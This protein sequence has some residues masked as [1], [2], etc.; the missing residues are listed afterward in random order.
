MHNFFLFTHQQ[1][2]SQ[3]IARS[4]ATSYLKNVILNDTCAALCL[5][6]AV[7]ERKLLCGA[8]DL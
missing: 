3:P 7:S 6:S 2:T 1:K 5:R 8:K 4:F